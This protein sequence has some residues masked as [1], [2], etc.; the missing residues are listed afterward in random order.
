VPT[1]ISKIHVI[2]GQFLDPTV[3]DIV[4]RKVV[5]HAAKNAFS[6]SGNF[7]PKRDERCNYGRLFRLR[8]KFLAFSSRTFL[9]AVAGNLGSFKGVVLALS[10]S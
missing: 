1:E 8:F 7:S 4:A 6:S 3:F 10:I 5:K 9:M 2:R